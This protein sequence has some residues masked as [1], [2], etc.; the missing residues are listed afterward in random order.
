MYHA[1]RACDISSI[2][3]C[4][5]FRSPSPPPSLFLTLLFSFSSLHCFFCFCRLYVSPGTKCGFT[6]E[7]PFVPLKD[8]PLRTNLPLVPVAGC[9]FCVPF[10]TATIGPE[11]F[12]LFF[13]AQQWL[14]RTPLLVES[15][16]P[17]HAPEF[18]KIRLDH[19][20]PAIAQGLK[21]HSKEI[22]A[23]AHN[24]ETASFANTVERLELSGELLRRT[25]KVFHNLC[26]ANTTPEL[27]ELE[28]KYAPVLSGHHDSI[29]LNKDLYERVKAVEQSDLSPLSAEQQ[30]LVT[31]T[32]QRFEIA[33]SHLGAAEKEELK[34]INQRLATLT[35]EFGNAM[36]EARNK[37]S[38]LLHN[39]L[40]L[41][42]LSADAVAKAKADA[43]K[44]GHPP[45]TYL[46]TLIN[47]VQQPMMTQITN[48]ETR[49]KLLEA[50]L[51]RATHT[52]GKSVDTTPMLEEMVRLRLRK[53]KLMGY[54]TFTE[55]KLLDQMANQSSAQQLLKDVSAHAITKAE[56]EAAEIRAYMKEAGITHELEPWDW[57]YYQELV[58]KKKYALD[59]KEVM[60]YMEFITVLEQGAFYA[61]TELYG[62][63]FSKRTDIPM[64]DPDVLCY[65]VFDVDKTPLALFCVDPYARENKKGGAW[66]TSCVTQSVIHNTRPVVYNCLNI[67]KP[68]SGKPTLL[69]A[70]HIKTIFHEFGHGLHGMLSMQTY[71]SLSG[72]SVSRDFVEFPS[73]IN[74]K[75][76]LYDKVLRHYAVHY[77][78]KK[79]IPDDIVRKM[80]ASE[81]FGVGFHSVE[82]MKASVIDLDWHMVSDE[83][84][85]LPAA[86]M[87]A[88]ALERYGLTYPLIPPRYTSSIFAHIFAGGYASGYYAYTWAKVLDC[89]GFEYFLQNGGLTRENG[90]K[91]RET[92]LSVGNSI[93]SNIAF[94]NFTGRDPTIAAYLR[95]TG[96][97][98]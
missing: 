59:E 36:L 50:S 84:D 90:A 33:G 9:R 52:D 14:S 27:Q 3:F 30:R 67:E 46:L 75:W 19:F 95:L 85:F 51:Q 83:K 53:A 79:P 87:E 1:V 68:P 2:L 34:A 55:W 25:L 81:L 64:Y 32:L 89:D 31:L 28:R 66:M 26:T 92:V 78:T 37:G 8:V 13:F 11:R 10:A 56:E 60:P 72:T 15:T 29:Y 21:E 82:L 48:R 38:L 35:T 22:D 42:G 20:E 63:T 16:L 39:E 96:L 86:E 12:V 98:A 91:F 58:R 43:E 47:T 65:E 40:E 80:K 69:S 18:D 97:K 94:R 17:F 4:L 7:F 76:A 41:E 49:R 6:E 62:I 23:I 93:D 74:E 57:C 73:Q 77:E 88:K 5:L 61:A 45:G 54:K 24:A 70:K 71:S 44:L